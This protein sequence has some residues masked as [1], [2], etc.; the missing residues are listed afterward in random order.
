MK[1]RE[2]AR[3]LV[4]LGCGEMPRKGGGSHR[5]WHNPATNRS[6]V[7]PDWGGRDLKM[8]T[9]RGAVRQL[10]IGWSAFESA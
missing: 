7:V 4:A 6:T 1:Y 2:V 8:G 5:K 10:G 9:V 3:R